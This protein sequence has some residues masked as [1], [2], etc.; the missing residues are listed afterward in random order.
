MKN[1]YTQIFPK[2]LDKT[3]ACDFFSNGEV[4]RKGEKCV[5]LKGRRDTYYLRFEH[6]KS[7]H[8]VQTA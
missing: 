3:S 7:L 4:Y 2:I 6:I 1:K 5:D 8:Y